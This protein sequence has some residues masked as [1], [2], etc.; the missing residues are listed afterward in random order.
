TLL[1]NVTNG[2]GSVTVSI[3]NAGPDNNPSNQIAVVS[4]ALVTNLGNVDFIPGSPIPLSPGA[5][6]VVVSPATGADNARVTWAY[7]DS[8][9][10][11]GFGMFGSYAD[12]SSGSWLNGPPLNYPQQMRLEVTPMAP[13]LGISFQNRAA[14]LSWPSILNGYMLEITT[15]LASPAW[16]IITNEPVSVAGDNVVTNSENGPMQFFR[17]RQIFAANN[18]DQTTAGYYGPIGTNA[19]TNGFL[20]GQQF[21]LPAGNYTLDKVTLLLDTINGG[22]GVTVSLWNVGSD[23]NPTNEIAVVAAQSVTGLGNADFVP[24]STIMLP[25]GSYYLVA[26]PTGTADNALVNWGYTA[27]TAWTGFGTLGG[28]ADTSYGVWVNYPIEDYPQ[29][30]S[31]EVTP[32]TP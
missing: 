10:W 31:V 6:Y 24:S 8:T 27:S 7:T 26:A 32:T 16:Q 21:S 3:W 22:G 5:Y 28:Y 17:L 4:S 1:L 23:N 15:N 19:N 14:L 18:L 9:N 25:A 12:T 11:T 2:G 20:I 30:M 29:Q 13:L